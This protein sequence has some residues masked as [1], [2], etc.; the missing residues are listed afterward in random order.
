MLNM[1]VGE[2]FAIRL[3]AGMIDNDGIV[4]YPHV[5]VLDGNGDPVVNGDVL[6]APPVYTSVKDVD[7]VEIKYG[8]VSALFAP[9][10]RLQRAAVLPAPGRRSRRPAA[11]DERRQPRQRRPVR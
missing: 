1:P 11:G 10:R 2:T 6:T 5:Y 9:E 3:N 7:D 4:D 8:R